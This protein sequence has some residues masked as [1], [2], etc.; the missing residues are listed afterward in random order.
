MT[1]ANHPRFRLLI[2]WCCLMS[3]A[4]LILIVC[5]AINRK[6]KPE[7]EAERK[8]Q[9]FT[10]TDGKT[11]QR[12]GLYPVQSVSDYIHLIRDS[13]EIWICHPCKNSS[14]T[15]KNSTVNI[16]VS[17][18]YFFHA[19]VTFQISNPALNTGSVTLLKNKALGIQERYLSR[20]KHS[21]SGTATMICLVELTE[22]DSISLEIHPNKSISSNEYDTYWEIMFLNNK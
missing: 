1:S 14:F 5:F 12:I 17:G 22:G 3:S 4:L 6:D 11:D 13:K 7:N 16:T 9:N 10:V 20:V 18:L 19:Q 8:E 2:G 21:G 15:H